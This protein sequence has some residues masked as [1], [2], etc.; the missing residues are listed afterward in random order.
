MSL[1]KLRNAV[2]VAGLGAAASGSALFS[3]DAY[4]TC[5]SGCK[6]TCL[7]CQPGCTNCNPQGTACQTAMKEV[8]VPIINPPG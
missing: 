4:A 6:E 7:T 5:M 8:S 1:D 2:K 3:D